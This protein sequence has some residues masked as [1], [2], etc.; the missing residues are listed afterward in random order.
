MQIK[1]TRYMTYFLLADTTMYLVNYKISV[2]ISHGYRENSAILLAYGRN[3]NTFFVWNI[4]FVSI[5]RERMK[6]NGLKR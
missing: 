3:V 6:W 2:P 1:I 4:L 5:S